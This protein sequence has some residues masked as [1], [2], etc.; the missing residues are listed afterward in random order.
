VI[1]VALGLHSVFF[2]TGTLLGACAGLVLAAQRSSAAQ[3]V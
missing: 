1:G 3:V 2:V